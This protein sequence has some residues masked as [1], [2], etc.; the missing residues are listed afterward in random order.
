MN[1]PNS[2]SSPLPPG[3]RPIEGFPRFGTHLHVPPPADPA[4]PVIEVSGAVAESFSVPLA[5]L[6][7]LPR[8]ELT[9][10]FH[11]V[12]GWSAT[13]L[14]WEGVAFE[15]FYRS[16]IE[17]SV[18]P[19]TPVTHIVFG[20]L[21]GYWSYMS[22]EDALAEDV[23]IADRLDGRPLDSDHGAPV[24][25][26]SP[27]HYG[28]INTKHLCRIE[29]RAAEPQGYGSSS[30]IA[31]VGLRLLGYGR[32]PRARVWEEERHRYLPAWSVRV[33]GRLFIPPTA[34][35]SARGSRRGRTPPARRSMEVDE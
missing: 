18:R 28:F 2:H 6:E 1:R 8:R 10:D 31:Q 20:G 7:T 33:L 17:P 23:L 22:I 29:L 19:D 25:L 35:L 32:P 27:N 16:V 13:N 30:S 26:V 9:A 15:T 34:F 11:C 5:E 14:H 3:Q 12:A 4:D 21:D 24:R